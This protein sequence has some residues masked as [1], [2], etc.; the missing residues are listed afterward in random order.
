MNFIF[1]IYFSFFSINSFSGPEHDHG[2]G[3]FSDEVMTPKQFKINDLKF[4]NLNIQSKKVE[5]IQLSDSFEMLA[6]TELLPNKQ[7][8][9]S[10]KFSGKILDINVKVGQKIKKGNRLATLKPITIANKNIQL[11][12]PID[13]LVLRQ[14]AKIGDVLNPGDIIL[15][16]GDTSKILIRGVA[17]ETPEIEK[18]KV[19]QKV[20]VHLDIFPN[21]EL[22]GVITRINPLIDPENRTFSVYALITSPFKNIRPGLQGLMEVFI[23]KSKPV[24]VIPKKALLGS[25]GSYFV[26]T[27]N[28]NEVEKKEVNIGVKKR[29]HVEILSGLKPDERVITN[30][31]YQ[32]QFLGVKEINS[33]DHEKHNHED[34]EKHNHEDHEKHNH[35]DHE[36]HNHEDHEKHNH[37]DHEK[38]NHEDHEKHNHEDHEKHNHED[39]EKQKK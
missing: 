37:E 14:F 35:E 8:T 38:H 29:H 6:F 25:F 17:Y 23:T 18:I 12:S 24:L 7:I 2:E 21:K 13:G 1:I 5:T 22:A 39:H 30:G 31:N 11:S 4:Q 10:P 19:G 26:F 15:E 28:G 20:E 36:K 16:I 9:I 32:L 33:H 27:I 3:A 34:H